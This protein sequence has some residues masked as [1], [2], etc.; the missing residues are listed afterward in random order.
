MIYTINLLYQCIYYVPACS[1]TFYDNVTNLTL[2]Y[3]N[4]K[5]EVYILYT[6]A[7]CSVEVEAYLIT[8][9]INLST[10]CKTN[11]I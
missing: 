10:R 6:E 7:Y 1:G 9:V 8:V 2:L 4:V 3:D 11:L 5:V